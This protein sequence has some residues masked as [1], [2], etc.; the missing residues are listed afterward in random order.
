MEDREILLV[1]DNP[2]D[3]ALAL[4]ALKRGGITAR[5]TIVRDGVEALD[6]LQIGEPSSPAP[7]RSLPHVVLLDLQLP[8]IDGMEVLRRIREND[9]TRNLLV[10]VLTSSVERTDIAQAYGLH[11]NSYIR[12]PVDFAQF[13][14]AVRQIGLYWLI[15]NEQPPVQRFR[16]AEPRHAKI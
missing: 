15:L 2:D 9:R 12:K 3:E 6:H 10:I 1:E 5:V 8:R 16:S 13:V 4:R 14:D 11:A 7:G